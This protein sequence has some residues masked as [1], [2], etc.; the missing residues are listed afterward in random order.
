MRLVALLS[1]YD[2]QTTDLERLVRSLPQAGVTHL[3]AL[4]GA[5][6]LYPNAQPA[7]SQ[8]EH[9]TLK[10]AASAAGL[11]FHLRIPPTPWQGNEVEKR[12]A[13]FHLAERL[14][15]PDDW[16]LVI[17]GD[18][19]LTQPADL[20]SLH[21]STFD[22]AEITY[23]E[24]KPDGQEY[25]V[26]SPRLFRAIR[27]LHCFRNHYTYRTPDGR[28]LWGNARTDRLEPRHIAHQLHMRHEPRDAIRRRQAQDYYTQRDAKRVESGRCQLCDDN[29]ATQRV[30]ANVHP[31]G[32]GYTADALELCTTCAPVFAEQNQA[33]ASR[34][35][36]DPTTLA[37]INI[38]A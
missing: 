35:G 2:E 14:T 21:D 13:L 6:C 10:Q 28:L 3:L 37:P 22:V 25:T 8:A 24:T 1:F 26:H 17:D 29:M 19:H 20:T 36:L 31:H 18:E 7:S 9:T 30:Y 12:T 15:T 32:K 23:T 38:A 16:Y 27:G 34:L 5:Y 33:T 4:D 11:T